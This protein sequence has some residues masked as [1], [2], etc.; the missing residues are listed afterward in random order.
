MDKNYQPGYNNDNI[1]IG[2]FLNKKSIHY[3]GD[4]TI[5][6]KGPIRALFY[7]HK[8]N[9]LLVPL[10]D[11]EMDP[12]KQ[13]AMV[14]KISARIPPPLMERALKWIVGIISPEERADY[15][16]ILKRGIPPERFDVMAGWVSEALS[17]GE[18]REFLSQMPELK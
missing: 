1:D 5:Q 8:E 7:V 3:R 6:I 12:G 14:G 4:E 10:T 11:K 18:W 16:G 15:L 17:E 9:D 2:N 13:G